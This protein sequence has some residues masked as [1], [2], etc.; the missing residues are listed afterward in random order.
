MPLSSRVLQINFYRA[1]C[2]LPL[3][4][5]TWIYIW[6]QVVSCLLLRTVNTNHLN[7][8]VHFVNYWGSNHWFEKWPLN[9]TVFHCVAL[10]IF[11]PYV[12][13]WLKCIVVTNENN[14]SFPAL[15]VLGEIDTRFSFCAAATLALLVSPKTSLEQVQCFFHWWIAEVNQFGW[16]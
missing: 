10:F 1:V 11:V 12:Q 9:G 8:N 7:C 13:W 16:R 15:H 5:L 14:I 4:E 3:V 2:K 6:M